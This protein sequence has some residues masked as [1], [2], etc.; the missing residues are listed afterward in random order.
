MSDKKAA[1][2]L[3]NVKFGCFI[4]VLLRM[5]S[6]FIIILHLMKVL[7]SNSVTLSFL[8]KMEVGTKNVVL[9]AFQTTFLALYQSKTVRP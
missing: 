4:E 8:L 2:Y 5:F 3:C 1:W 6:V 9:L 7:F